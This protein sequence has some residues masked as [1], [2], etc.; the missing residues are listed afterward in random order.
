MG[1]PNGEFGNFEA[2]KEE[3]TLEP[4][5]AGDKAGAAILTIIMLSLLIG[6]TYWLFADANE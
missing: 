6:T 3:H 4:A 5:T 2:K 1:A